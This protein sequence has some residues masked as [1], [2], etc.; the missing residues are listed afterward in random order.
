[1]KDSQRVGAS[2]MQDALYVAAKK[3]YPVAQ[4][5]VIVRI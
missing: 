3:H 1:M 5:T 4:N 2:K